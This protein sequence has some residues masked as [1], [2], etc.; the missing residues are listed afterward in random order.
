MFRF[1]PIPR[2]RKKT[3]QDVEGKGPNQLSRL[4]HCLPGCISGFFGNC[5]CNNIRGNISCSCWSSSS[6]IAKVSCFKHKIFMSAFRLVFGW[7]FSYFFSLRKISL[8]QVCLAAVLLKRFLP[9]Q[10]VEPQAE[11]DMA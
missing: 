6:Q 11:A 5:N 9:G 3:M 8:L 7:V 1:Y 10:K 2:S 4:P